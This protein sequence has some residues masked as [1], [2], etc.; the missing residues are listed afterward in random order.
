MLVAGYHNLRKKR[1]LEIRLETNSLLQAA[2]NGSITVLL[3]LNWALPLSTPLILCETR[4][5]LQDP[6]VKCVF[7][8]CTVDLQRCVHRF[9]SWG[10]GVPGPRPEDLVQGRDGGDPQ[11]PAVC[12]WGSLHPEVGICPGVPLHVTSVP[13]ESPCFSWPSSK[14]CWLTH[15]KLC[16]LHQEFKLV[17]PSGDLPMCDIQGVFPQLKHL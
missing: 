17:F 8:S 1:K 14:P 9:H 5:P 16:D 11:E 7:I 13:F 2:F 12:G 3:Q 15:V 6:L 4:N 10:V